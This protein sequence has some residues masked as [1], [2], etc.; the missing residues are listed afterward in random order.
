M[1]VGNLHLN[2]TSSA[3]SSELHALI[4]LFVYDY[5]GEC[6]GSVSAEH[7][8]GFAK[9]KYIYRSKSREAVDVMRQLKQLFDPNAILNPYKTLP[10]E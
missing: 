1:S 3:Y 5:V 2:V 6:H 8:L 4:E 9:R 7:G 10:R